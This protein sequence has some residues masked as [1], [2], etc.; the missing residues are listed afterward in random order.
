M[1]VGGEIAD[2]ARI[3]RPSIGVVTAVQA[4][5]LSRIGSLDAIEAAKGELRRGAAGRR[6]RRSS[7]PTTRSSG[8]WAPGRPRGRISYGFADDADVGAEEVESLGLDGMRFTLRAG[9]RAA[10][11]RDPGARAGSRSTTRWRR[12]RSGS[13]PA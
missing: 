8:G 2:L 1:Y 13:P 11:V 7:T 12:R 6:R 10:D 3:A 9:R 5:H 4:V